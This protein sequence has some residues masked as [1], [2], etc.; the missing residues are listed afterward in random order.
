[1]AK[2]ILKNDY[3]AGGQRFRKHPHG[4]ATD[5]PTNIIRAHGLPK[6]A[7]VVDEDYIA[8]KPPEDDRETIAEAAAK[9]EARVIAEA[10]GTLERRRRRPSE[11]T[12]EGGD[13]LGG[14]VK[15]IVAK[16]SDMGEAELRKLLEDEREGK[17]RPS[18]IVEIEAAIE[19]LNR[20]D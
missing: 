11:D 7:K 20:V 17:G 14:S 5:I 1:M 19:D 13:V 18:L 12:T 16:L 3:I 10:E 9:D 15:A 6:S 2:V 8:P 4:G